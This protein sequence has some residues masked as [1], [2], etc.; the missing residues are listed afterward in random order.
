M[1]KEEAEEEEEVGGK[2][3]HTET[4]IFSLCF[5]P[6]RYLQIIHYTLDVGQFDGM[7]RFHGCFLFQVL[8]LFYNH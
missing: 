3:F 1:E 4:V 2:T 5:M 8:S 7:H 6:D